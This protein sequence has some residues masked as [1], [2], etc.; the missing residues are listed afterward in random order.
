[1][2]ISWGLSDYQCLSWFGSPPLTLSLPLFPCLTIQLASYQKYTEIGPVELE[3]GLP[4]SV[5]KILYCETPASVQPKCRMPVITSIF[6]FC[7]NYWIK[8]KNWLF[9][10][11][12]EV[13]KQL[14]EDKCQLVWYKLIFIHAMIFFF[15]SHC[16]GHQWASLCRWMPETDW[17]IQTQG[18]N[19]SC[20]GYDN[21]D[22]HE[23]HHLDSKSA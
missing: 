7:T 11:V 3:G 23:V 5:Y 20:S 16:E 15:N 10:I 1:M 21:T 4:V 2:F 12:G 22:H 6:F 9:Q 14:S 18:W 13:L 8:L 19:P 17:Q